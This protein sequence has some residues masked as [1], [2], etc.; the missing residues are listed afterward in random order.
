MS[1]ASAML[2]AKISTR[3]ACS[4]QGWHSTMCSCRR[5]R[6]SGPNTKQ[7]RPNRAGLAVQGTSWRMLLVL[8]AP[9]MLR[10]T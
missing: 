3:M 1:S 7:E 4:N 8:A 6:L 2:L 5:S 10:R 9:S